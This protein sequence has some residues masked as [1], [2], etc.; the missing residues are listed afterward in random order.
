[1]TLMY[2]TEIFGT[3]KETVKDKGIDFVNFVLESGKLDS[4]CKNVD[5]NGREYQSISRIEQIGTRDSDEGG[6]TSLFLEKAS[7][8]RKAVC[9]F[10]AG[11]I[12]LSSLCDNTIEILVTTTWAGLFYGFVVFSTVKKI[13]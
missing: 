3:T 13:T 11:I 4:E 8:L 6:P 5:G 1:M 10:T 12:M 2:S 9:D 7:H